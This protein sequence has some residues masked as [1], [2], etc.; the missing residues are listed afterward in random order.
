MKYG[1]NKHRQNHI[2]TF[3]IH[4]ALNK[5]RRTLCTWRHT[6]KVRRKHVHLDCRNYVR[7]LSRCTC[8]KILKQY[9]WFSDWA[10]HFS[11]DSSLLTIKKCISFTTNSKTLFLRQRKIACKKKTCKNTHCHTRTLSNSSHYLS[12][13]GEPWWSALWVVSHFA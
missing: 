9:K 8:M 5:H 4:I 3:T 2:L 1:S 7:G 6:F 10:D 13:L 11:V 12:E